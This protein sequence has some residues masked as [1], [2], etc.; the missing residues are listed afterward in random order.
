MS[1]LHKNSRNVT[2]VLFGKNS[3]VSVYTIHFDHRVIANFVP[4]SVRSNLMTKMLNTLPLEKGNI[5]LHIFT[6]R[7][8]L[9]QYSSLWEISV[10]EG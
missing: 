2:F 1:I 8:P 10:A 7:N 3:N 6:V 9:H 4:I 5:S